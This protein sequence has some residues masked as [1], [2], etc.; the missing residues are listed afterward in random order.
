ML[1]SIMLRPFLNN[2]KIT[3]I[4]LGKIGHTNYKSQ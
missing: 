4:D 2:R 1:H 3:S